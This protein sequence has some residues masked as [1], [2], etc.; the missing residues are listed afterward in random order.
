MTI[1]SLHNLKTALGAKK[2]KIRRGRGNSSKGNYSGRGMKGQRAR[3]GGKSGLGLKGIRGYLQRIP[4][5][6]GFTSF[7]LKPQIVNLGALE[8]FFA[9]G[10]T[11]TPQSLFRKGLIKATGGVKILASGELKKKF[12]ISAHAF[13]ASAKD[14]IVK[15][16]GQAV[17]IQQSNKT[18]KQESKETKKQKAMQ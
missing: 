5:R 14:A 15:A 3:S 18:I 2:R 7:R 16:G 9:D 13:S 6:G 10:E 11:V 1:L 8:K 12:I 4:K 17:I